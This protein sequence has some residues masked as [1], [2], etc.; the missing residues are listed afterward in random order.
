M[1]HPPFFATARPT[2]YVSL[3]IVS[4]TLH[5]PSI[6]PLDTAIH[7]FRH[8]TS[9]IGS[10]NILGPFTQLMSVRY[11]PSTT[12]I[13]S[14]S[15][16]PKSRPRHHSHHHPPLPAQLP[17]QLYIRE[18]S[19]PRREQSCPRRPSPPKEKHVRFGETTVVGYSAELRKPA[20]A[21]LPARSSRPQP[22][23]TR[24][25]RLERRQIG[26]PT[27]RTEAYSGRSMLGPPRWSWEG[28]DLKLRHG[29]ERKRRAEHVEIA[30]G[31]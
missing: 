13:M 17:R 6:H 4:C 11:R 26:P 31:R 12:S 1:S 29:C 19:R 5:V 27:P 7:T 8:S 25:A 2:R 22:L 20:P 9:Y 21:V 10:F 16:S 30:Y 18:Q 14:S 3:T 15:S 23:P 28:T 24:P